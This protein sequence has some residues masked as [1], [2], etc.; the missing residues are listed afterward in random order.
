MV[1]RH[2]DAFYGEVGW[3]DLH[4]AG[5]AVM[6]RWESSTV[7]GGHAA[8]GVTVWNEL[9]QEAVTNALVSVGHVRRAT[10]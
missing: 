7:C 10:V 5:A 9:G 4:G 6:P 8:C 2:V 3:P 1:Q